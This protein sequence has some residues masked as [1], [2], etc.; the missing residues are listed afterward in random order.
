MKKATKRALITSVLAMLLCCTMLVG[1]TFAWFTDSVT[2]ANNKIIAGDLDVD[3]LVYDG[4]EYKSIANTNASIF[5]DDN[6]VNWEPGKTEIV[7]LAVANEGTLDLKYNIVLNI[8]GE[9]APALEYA[10]LDGV[11]A[12]VTNAPTNWTELKALTS[13]TADVTVGKIVA[14]Q[15]GQLESE[16]SDYFAFA[17]HMKD[18]AS[19]EFEEK[20]ITVDVTVIATQLASELDSFGA[21][22]D[23]AAPLMPA[24]DGSSDSEGLTEVS[25]TTAKTVKISTPEQLKAFADSV[26]AGN[27]YAGYT[28]TLEKSIDLAGKAWR[29]IGDKPDGGLKFEGTFD[30]QGNIIKNLYVAQGANQN[31]VGFFGCST[32]TATTVKNVIFDN[33]TVVSG[34]AGGAEGTAVVFG[35]LLGGTIENVTVRNSTVNGHNRVG[36]IAGYFNGT[37]KGCKVEGCE[38]NATL[39]DLG[40]NTFDRGDKA[41]ALIGYVNSNTNS[42]TDC[43]VKQVKVSGFREVGGIVGYGA[44][45][46]A[47]TGNSIENAEISY[48]TLPAGG[49]MDDSADVN[50]SI[51]AFCGKLPT[52]AIDSTNTQSGVVIK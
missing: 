6:G 39:M 10:I 31:S 12:P 32:G 18:D 27:S 34:K 13:Q 15:N 25:D 1:T 35:A 28:V 7:Y 47:F 30:G 16:T 51:G 22:Y 49:A 40:N 48:I 20:R 41:G 17:V 23:A 5:G 3:L 2:S 4:A 29:P 38:I 46:Q 33:A 21:D 50:S 52:F 37:I 9:L 8:A 42:V 26:N 45:I 11:K 24:W 14:A 19:S 43:S 36:A 44:Y